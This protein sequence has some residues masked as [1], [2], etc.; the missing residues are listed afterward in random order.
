MNTNA[1]VMLEALRL[2]ANDTTSEH[3]IDLLENRHIAWAPKGVTAE[4]LATAGRLGGFLE[5][6]MSGDLT[7]AWRSG[8]ESNQAALAAVVPQASR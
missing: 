7:L 2:S 4:Y 5:A 3:A 8:D 1:R 6:V